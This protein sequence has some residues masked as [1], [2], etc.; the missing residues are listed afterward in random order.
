MYIIKAYI[1]GLTIAL[2]IGPI[3]LLVVQRCIR[4]GLKSA[5]VTSLGIAIADFT[6]ALIALSIGTSILLLMEKYEHYV[7]MF[8][9]VVLFGLALY[10][11]HSA[12]RIYSDNI[13]MSAAKAEGS[14]FFSGYLLT[15]HNP[16]T[17]AVFLGFLS[18]MTNIHSF[19]GILFF[20]FFLFLGSY[21]GQLIIGLTA[22]VFRGFFQKPKAILLFDCLSALGIAAF[23]VFSFLKVLNG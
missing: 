9:G 4:K 7:Y 14:D 12:L 19:S 5:I 18:Y 10:I 13:H 3:S 8:S 23:A 2:T 21:T 20:A 6:F 11:S 17:V 22:Y 16:M 1:I 15:I